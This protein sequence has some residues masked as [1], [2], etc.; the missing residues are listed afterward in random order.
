MLHPKVIDPVIQE[1]FKP[2][3]GQT[4]WV[5]ELTPNQEQFLVKSHSLERNDGIL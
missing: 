2:I 3:K 1:S 5:F 4:E